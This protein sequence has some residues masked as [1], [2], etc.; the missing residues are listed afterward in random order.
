MVELEYYGGDGFDFCPHVGLFEVIT[1]NED[2]QFTNLVDAKEYYDN[3]LGQVVGSQGE[4]DLVRSVA[5]NIT[6]ELYNSTKLQYEQMM[7]DPVLR[8]RLGM[9]KVDLP[10]DEGLTEPERAINH[11]HL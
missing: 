5:S 4:D 7:S 1:K 3:I 6:P 11:L 9:E 8:K 10:P 2:R